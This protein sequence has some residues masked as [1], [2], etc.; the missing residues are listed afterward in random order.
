MIS[1]MTSRSMDMV[2]SIDIAL[3]AWRRGRRPVPDRKYL[4]LVSNMI[5]DIHDWIKY[6]NVPTLSYIND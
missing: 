1:A 2:D 3:G 5:Y 4:R 6:R